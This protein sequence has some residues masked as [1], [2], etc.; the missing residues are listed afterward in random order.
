MAAEFWSGLTVGAVGAFILNKLLPIILKA[1]FDAKKDRKKIIVERSNKL[2][3]DVHKLVKA[4]ISCYCLDY[5]REVSV[6]IRADFQSVSKLVNELNKDLGAAGFENMQIEPRIIVDLRQ[7]ITGK[8]FEI[9]SERYNYSD[10]E[11]VHI[12][13]KSD[14]L[15]ER[16]REISRQISF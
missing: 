4:A 6:S 7:A 13:E 1:H 2:C 11:I 12:D 14:L 9:R 8:L 10:I 15:L 3:D 16:L 5:D